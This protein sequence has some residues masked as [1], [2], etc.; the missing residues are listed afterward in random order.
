MQYQHENAAEEQAAY[1]A[2][3]DKQP[4]QQLAS[5]EFPPDENDKQHYTWHEMPLKPGF[6][7]PVMVHRAILGSVERF[8]AILCEHLAGKWPFWLSPRQ[9]IVCPI[10]EK[11]MDYC[12]SVYLYLHKLGYQVELDRSQGNINKKV[13]N[14]QLAQWNYILVAGEAEMAEGLLDVRTRDNKR[15]GKIRVDEVASMMA[16]ESPAP[17]TVSKNFYAKA[18][19]PVQFFGEAASADVQR[20]AAPIKKAS[21]GPSP[22]EKLAEI[23]QQLQQSG[24]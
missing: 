24:C 2:N 3:K 9:A 17:A 15:H 1:A 20:A 23:E 19:D 8:T 4:K 18:F 7:R 12:E 10:S 6:R 13:R 22:M 5:Q 16:A 11:A 21:A 14:A